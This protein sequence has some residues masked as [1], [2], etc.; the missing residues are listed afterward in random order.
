MQHTCRFVFSL[1]FVTLFSSSRTAN[2]QESNA[3]KYPPGLIVSSIAKGS[4]AEQAGLKV[5]DL[6]LSFDNKP[7]RFDSQN[8]T[9]PR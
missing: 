5:G 4:P 7:L 3:E 6:L 1:L 8:C 2:A 9:I